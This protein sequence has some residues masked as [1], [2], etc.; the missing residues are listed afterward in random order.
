[1]YPL[2]VHSE[3]PC[4]VAANSAF[5]YTPPMRLL[6][7]TQKLHDQ[8]TFTILW[9][10]AFIKQGFDVSVV[11]LENR[12]INLEFPVYSMGKEKGNGK[13]TEV[14]HYWRLIRT[15]QYDRVFIHMAPIYGAL[16]A[17][18]W[19]VKRIPVYL[20]YTHYHMSVSFRIMSLFTKRFFCA[21]SASL[22]QF[23]H[24]ARKVVTGHGIDLSFWKKQPNVATDPH[25]ILVVHRLA[26]SKQLEIGIRALALLPP[27]YTMTVYG[28]PLE[29]DYVAELHALVEELRLNDRVRFMGAVPMQELPG[30][31]AS[32]RILLNMAHATIDKTMAEALSCGMWVVTTPTNARDIGL[33]KAPRDIEPRSVADFIEWCAKEPINADKAYGI[34]AEKHDLTKTI[35]TMSSYISSGN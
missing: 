24:D 12:S 14:L 35:A 34:L 29:K 23:N 4:I 15:L 10:R 7:V 20:W 16:G 22:P 8:D 31:F 33:S 28:A 5:H 30:V 11:C 2:S 17:W 25:A 26:R 13:L 27:D 32:H 18:Y 3:E 19:P 6:F 9:I 21:G 1:M